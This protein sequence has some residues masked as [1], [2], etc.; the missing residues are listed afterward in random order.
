[1]QLFYLLP[2]W[3]FVK[4]HEKLGIHS[5]NKKFAPT[6]QVPTG[7]GQHSSENSK[8]DAGQNGK[9]VSEVTHPEFRKLIEELK[10]ATA[11]VKKEIQQAKIARGEISET[12]ADESS[13]SN[14]TSTGNARRS[15]RKN[16]GVR[17]NSK[18][19]NFVRSW[20]AASHNL[21][22]NDASLKQV[23]SVRNMTVRDMKHLPR[24]LLRLGTIPG[25]WTAG[26]TT[27]MSGSVMLQQ[28][29]HSTTSPSIMEYIYD[30]WEEVLEE[31]MASG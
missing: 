23:T 20:Y 3:L 5:A 29:S 14:S 9:D 31:C 4:F 7:G 13:S 17:S 28:N 16:D 2:A 10:Q 26:I 1:M 30:M 11:S 22:K 6:I 27:T 12:S 8:A 18:Y 15:E 21:A 25:V 24:Q 19:Q